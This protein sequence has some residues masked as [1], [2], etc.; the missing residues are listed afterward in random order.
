M[1]PDVVDVITPH[2]KDTQF[3]GA[4]GHMTG[5]GWGWGSS[6]SRNMEAY[7]FRAFG[8]H[9]S[10]Q[11]LLT[12]DPGTRTLLQPTWEQETPTVRTQIDC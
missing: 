5:V 9:W 11:T 1:P 3:S 8:T 10:I 6:H 2:I 4:L 7:C 12:L